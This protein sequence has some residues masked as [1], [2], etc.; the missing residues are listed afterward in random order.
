MTGQ[1]KSEESKETLNERLKKVWM[2]DQKTEKGFMNNQ[3]KERSLKGPIENNGCEW[4]ND[5]R[6]SDWM[7]ETEKGCVFLFSFVIFLW[8]IAI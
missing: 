2:N 7:N 4:M 6:K 1:K 3:T 5:E 8:E